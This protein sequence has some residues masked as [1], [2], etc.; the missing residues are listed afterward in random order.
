MQHIRRSRNH[1]DWRRLDRNR[2]YDRLE[3]LVT[4]NLADGQKFPTVSHLQSHMINQGFGANSINAFMNSQRGRQFISQR[5]ENIYATD[6]LPPDT[7]IGKGPGVGLSS[8]PS[9]FDSNNTYSE[10]EGGVDQFSDN[11]G[12]NLGGGNLT[13]GQKGKR[14]P[15]NIAAYDRLIN[16]FTL[17]GLDSETARGVLIGQ[18]FNS[19]HVNSFLESDYVQ[20]IIFPHVETFIVRARQRYSETLSLN[21]QGTEAFN[22]NDSVGALQ[23]FQSA[24]EMN[25]ITMNYLEK[26]DPADTRL[27]ELR[28]RMVQLCSVVDQN[29]IAAQKSVWQ[30]DI[31]NLGNS[32]SE[33]ENL[34]KEGSFVAASN[35]LNSRMKEVE[36]LIAEMRGKLGEDDPFLQQAMQL[37]NTFFQSGLSSVST[38]SQGTQQVPQTSGGGSGTLGGWQRG[39]KIAEGGMGQVFFATMSD[40]TQGVWKQAYGKHLPLNKTRLRLREEAKFL[41]EN[42]HFRIPRLL[43][44]GAYNDPEIGETD[45]LIM[46]FIEGGNLQSDVE[47]LR[48]AGS[49]F[50]THRIIELIREIIEPLSF[51]LRRKVPAYHRDLKPQN[52]ILH[53]KRGSVLIDWGLVKE[54]ET[55]EDLSVTRGGSG[56]WTAPERSS[57]ISGPFTDVHSLGKIM[58]FLAT[59][60]KPPLILNQSNLDKIKAFGHP[61]WLADL[62]NW[63]CYPHHQQRVQSV[64]QLLTL[65]ENNGVWPEHQVEDASSS[66]DDFTTWS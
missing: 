9:N 5:V 3:N 14:I 47:T 22:R 52:V 41:E 39:A 13:S 26:T 35:I 34:R 49:T 25:E 62:I 53:P 23:H 1:E 56:V 20:S 58:Y 29:L 43:A 10:Q 11:V 24:K 19:S 16:E 50:S 32:I 4:I 44:E 59:N 63:A 7:K 6:M 55:V 65:L 33:I 21:M 46:E 31:D 2:S 8:S 51:L 27:A 54:V 40:G 36:D 48:K 66:S 15:S 60:E 61:K 18:G 30:K 42:P 17:S 28:E 57:G 64:D 38:Y 12:S 45:V 37:G